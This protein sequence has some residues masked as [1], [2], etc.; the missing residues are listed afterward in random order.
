MSNGA[1]LSCT[2]VAS[3]RSFIC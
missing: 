1:V 2:W 3:C